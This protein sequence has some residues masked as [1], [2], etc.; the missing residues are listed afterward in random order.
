MGMSGDK[1][2]NSRI[3]NALRDCH[4]RTIPGDRR[5]ISHRVLSVGSSLMDQDDLYP[6]APLAQL[7]RLSFDRGDFIQEQQTLSS[8]CADKFRGFLQFDANDA[9]TQT[10]ILKDASTLYPVRVS[11]GPFINNVGSQEGEIGAR[12]MF[13]QAFNPIIELMVAIG[14]GIQSPGIFYINRWHIL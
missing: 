5:I 13:E 4:D 8:A 14:C 7:R 11:H 2:V 9:D 12:L 10:P 3:L 6:D 1:H